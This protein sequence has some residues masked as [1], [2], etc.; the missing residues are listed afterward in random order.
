MLGEGVPQAGVPALAREEVSAELGQL[1][2]QEVTWALEITNLHYE[3]IT[4]CFHGEITFKLVNS[5]KR[6]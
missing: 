1:L 6:S 3:I 5:L 4:S 2:L